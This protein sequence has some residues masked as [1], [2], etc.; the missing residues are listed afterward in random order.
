MQTQSSSKFV[1]ESS[2]NPI[3]T[4]SKR[5]NRR[6]SK[7]RVELFSIVEIPIVTMA[8]NRTLEEMLQAPT[9]CYGDA[10]VVPY[11]LAENFEIRTGLLSLIQGN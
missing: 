8:D 11:I 6:R 2:T 10:I 3:Y 5:R 4:N 7:P 9:E 1:S